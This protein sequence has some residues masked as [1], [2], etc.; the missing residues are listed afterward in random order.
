MTTG[1]CA[2]VTFELAVNGSVVIENRCNING[3]LFKI[4]T[5]NGKKAKNAQPY[6]R[7]LLFGNGNPGK[8]ITTFDG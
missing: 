1:E 5:Y 4:N 8:K 7:L 6:I 3:N 2:I